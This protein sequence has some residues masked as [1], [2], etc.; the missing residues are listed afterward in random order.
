MINDKFWY[1]GVA[2]RIAAAGYA[3]F[4][5]DYPGFGLSDGLHGYINSFDELANTAIEHYGKI[6]GVTYSVF[7]CY[8]S[9]T[10]VVL[11]IETLPQ[12]KDLDG[13][14]QNFDLQVGLNWKGCPILYW[15]SPWAELFL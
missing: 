13:M 7:Q 8:L 14:W 4:A 15:G 6:K 2:K 5:F 10:L 11:Y 9:S 12:K 3:V 1:S